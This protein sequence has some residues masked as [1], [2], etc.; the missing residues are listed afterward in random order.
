MKT[1]YLTRA[2]GPDVFPCFRDGFKTIEA[3]RKW[4]RQAI[5]DGYLF[6]DIV[7]RVKMDIKLIEVTQ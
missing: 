1:A 7:Q 4:A 2:Y 5:T 6:V 3:A